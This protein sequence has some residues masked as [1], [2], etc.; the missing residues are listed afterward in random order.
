MPVHRCGRALARAGFTLIELLVVMAIIATLASVAVPRYF[1]SLEKAK[2]T[3]LRTN[4]KVM[5]EAISQYHEDTGKWP[6]SLEDLVKVR[7]LREV[8]PDPI[9]G[10]ATTWAAIRSTDSNSPGIM[11][12]RSGAPGNARDGIAYEAW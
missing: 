10:E 4:L 9:T 1:Q 6:A 12:V 8:P 11:D 2:E 5:R 3:A 7:Y